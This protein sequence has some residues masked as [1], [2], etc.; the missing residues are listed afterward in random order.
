[1]AMSDAQNLRNFYWHKPIDRMPMKGA[2][3]IKCTPNGI[4]ERPFNSGS[5]IDWFGVTWEGGELA[6][7]AAPKIGNYVL[8][9]IEQWRD[10]VNF[11]NLDSWDWKHA[12]EVDNVAQ[13][14]RDNNIVTVTILNGP[15]E[16][17]NQLMGFENAL[18]A[19]IESPDET[20][21]FLDAMRDYKCKLIDY[22]ATWYKPDVI[23]CHDD[24]GAQNGPFFAPETWREFIKPVTKSIVEKVHEYG[25]AYEQH[26]CGKYD[27]LFP[28]IEEIGIDTMQCMDI[29]DIAKAIEVTHGNV[30]FYVG[31]HEQY[32]IG[33][34]ATGTLTE[35]KVREICR[36]DFY[37]LGKTGHWA[38]YVFAPK[39]WY[40]EVILDEFLKAQADLAGTY[41]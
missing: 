40:E 38:P 36:K 3:E 35:E 23:M 19:F 37:S 17:M 29:N 13:W 2:G 31:F 28:D 32:F 20:R 25:I 41:F 33:A 9:D 5:G 12:V 27:A 4:V 24:W 6:G 7:A 30:S 39:Q 11:P 21:A 22:V 34:D 8:N 10:V 26:S 15:W 16:R 1:M 14:D 18:C